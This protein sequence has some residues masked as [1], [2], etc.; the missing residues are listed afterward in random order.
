MAGDIQYGA[1]DLEDST[2]IHPDAIR[3]HQKGTDVQKGWALHTKYFSYLAI[4]SNDGRI[5]VY[6]EW[7]DDQPMDV[8]W[9]VDWEG[10]ARY[11]KI[12]L[13]TFKEGD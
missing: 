1:H 7:G 3:V 2:K 10:A 11:L 4:K 5:D 9:F 6:V 13:G 8:T 12:M